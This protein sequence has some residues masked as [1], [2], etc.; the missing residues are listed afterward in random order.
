MGEVQEGDHREDGTHRGTQARGVPAIRWL[1]LPLLWD[2]TVTDDRDLAYRIC[3]LTAG[4][5]A[6]V[7]AAAW[8]LGGP[9][10]AAGALVGGAI[11]IGNFLWLRWTAGLALRKA[12]VGGGIM[13]ALW[14]GASGARFGLVALAL[15]L[16]AV[17]GSLGLVG[18]L[19]A[20]T[21]LPC[22]VVAEGLRAARVS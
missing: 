2:I 9:A 1:G 14:V 7:A 11:T 21:A 5:V 4:L 16:V 8:S 20:L 12:P 17:Q 3:G 10:E 18:L 19:V 6:L 15:G 13:R 22:T